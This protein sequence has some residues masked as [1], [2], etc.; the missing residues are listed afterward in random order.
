MSD[1]DA[2]RSPLHQEQPNPRLPDR[3]KRHKLSASEKAF[4]KAKRDRVVRERNRVKSPDTSQFSKMTRPGSMTEQILTLLDEFSG[5][6]VIVFEKLR[7][8]VRYED[9][10]DKQLKWQIAQVAWRFG[11]HKR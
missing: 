8:N 4:L 11:F 6:R 2:V 9:K 1:P 7:G 10:T 5:D 3:K